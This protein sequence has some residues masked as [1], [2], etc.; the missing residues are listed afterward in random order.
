M[1]RYDCDNTIIWYTP[2]ADNIYNIAVGNNIIDLKENSIIISQC[3]LKK[4]TSY[5]IT[6]PV[7]NL[8]V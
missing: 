1:Y 4:F 6:E 5:T 3:V 8:K 7:L 2:Y